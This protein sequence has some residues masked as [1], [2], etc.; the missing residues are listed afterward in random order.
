GEKIKWMIGET[1]KAFASR[2]SDTAIEILR[3]SDEDVDV[4]EERM[5][6]QL[7]ADDA[8]VAV[9]KALFYRYAMR[10]TA[11]LMNVL[12]AVVMPFERLDYWDEDK[13][14]REPE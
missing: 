3:A 6:G 11:H 12:T 8:G 13:I 7:N 1:R 5:H 14:D 10:I 4:Y 9:A 2:D